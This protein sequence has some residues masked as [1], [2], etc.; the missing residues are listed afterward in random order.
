MDPDENTGLGARLGSAREARDLTQQQAAELLNLDVAVVE[1]LE[2]ED[3]AALGAP[4]FA[5]GH[6]RRYGL[7][8]GFEESALIDAYEAVRERPEVPSLIPRARQEMQPTRARPK[9]PWVTGGA[10]L[11]LLVAATAAYLAGYG[12]DEP[13]TSG[14]DASHD[15]DVATAPAASPVPPGDGA[16]AADAM[17]A[18]GPAVATD[19]AVAQPALPLPP[20]HVS[21]TFSFAADS[22]IEI[23]DG[24][25]KAVLYD[26]GRAGSQRTIA[27]AAPLS[28]TFGNGSAVTLAVNGRAVTVPVPAGQTVARFQV[29]T[30]GS[31]R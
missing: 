27:A 7:L 15:A 10:I 6:L 31:L 1:A 26:L 30:D 12:V 3:F 8:L 13:A 2:R 9:W 17:Q 21:L 19:P 28:V 22:W 25:G 18:T 29:E 14:T 24:S 16:A 4:V 5:R 23:Y 20:G 11:F